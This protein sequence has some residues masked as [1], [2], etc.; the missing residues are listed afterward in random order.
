M[1]YNKLTTTEYLNLIAEK[2]QSVYPSEEN[3]FIEILDQIKTL[4]EEDLPKMEVNINDAI[5]HFIPNAPIITLIDRN[6]MIQMIEQG[7]KELL[8]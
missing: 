3:L 2:I 5:A 1:D 4:K 7:A 8:N 6:R